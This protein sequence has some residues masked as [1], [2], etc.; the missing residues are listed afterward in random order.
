MLDWMISFRIRTERFVMNLYFFIGGKFG[1]KAARD[2]NKHGLGDWL[3]QIRRLWLKLN[4]FTSNN[5]GSIV[6]VRAWNVM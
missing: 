2:V 4:A 3:S 6:I 1:W 5:L